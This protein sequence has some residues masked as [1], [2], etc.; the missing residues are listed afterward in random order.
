MKLPALALLAL[1]TCLPTSAHAA[2]VKVLMAGEAKTDLDSVL[3]LAEG[4]Q[5][6]LWLF[7]YTLS[8][9]GLLKVLAE[10]AKQ[11]DFD[12]R[13]LID[14]KQF[15]KLKS[16][17]SVLKGKL[18][19]I[20]VPAKGRM[21]VKL[22]LVDEHTFVAG[23]KNWSHLPSLTKWNDLVIVRD[24]KLVARVAQDFARV[25]GFRAKRAKTKAAPRAPGME[26][27]RAAVR[28]CAPGKLGAKARAQI[29]GMIKRAK[30]RVLV[31]MFVLNDLELAKAIHKQRRKGVEVKVVLAAVQHANLKR[32][33]DRNAKALLSTLEALGP[34][35]KL[36]RGKQVHHKFAVIDEVVVTG[37]ANWTKAAW[38]RN[39][40]VVLILRR[41]KKA[42][43]ARFVEAYVKRHGVLWKSAE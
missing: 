13:V 2:E 18:T 37:S 30:K 32:R 5:R 8:D 24:S 29:L 40:E 7:A 1:L 11:P 42:K 27:A 39:H 35:L 43:R 6:R 23:S 36:C 17:L 20:K 15:S 22:L 21:H 4:A 10:K 26:A 19:Q 34:G 16:K 41:A 28:F 25:G 33:K 9:K 14:S 3:K 38:G 31:A 12:L